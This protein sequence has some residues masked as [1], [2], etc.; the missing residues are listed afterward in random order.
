MSHR[1]SQE[2]LQT[3]ADGILDYVDGHTA[4]PYSTDLGR[5]LVC[6]A[7][8]ETPRQIGERT[9]NFLRLFKALSG[10]TLASAI[11]NEFGFSAWEDSDVLPEMP[12]RSLT[13]KS[14]L[15]SSIHVWEG[16]MDANERPITSSV[17]NDLMGDVETAVPYSASPRPDGDNLGYR[18]SL[19][20]LFNR[21][22]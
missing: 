9:A 1:A 22:R 14:D 3:A 7:R 13:F 12:V 5:F 6:Y 15:L 16:T 4:E 21:P 2:E 20:F 10:D 17:A 19:P 8:L 18:T 11:Y